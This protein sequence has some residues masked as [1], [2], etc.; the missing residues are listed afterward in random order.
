MTI[1][2]SQNDIIRV[3]Q[4]NRYCLPAES[5]NS[6]LQQSGNYTYNP[7]SAPATDTRP[8][9]NKV[10][11]EREETHPVDNSSHVIYYSVI[12]CRDGLD[13]VALPATEVRGL[14]IPISETT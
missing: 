8:C 3:Y 1:I 12:E 14:I 7:R 10:D 13:R 6:N 4:G 5:Y 2:L 9:T 11:V